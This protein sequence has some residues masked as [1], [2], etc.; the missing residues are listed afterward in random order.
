MGS[1]YDQALKDPQSTIPIR[2]CE[3]Q[4]I[5][6]ENNPKP[7][8]SELKNTKEM[9]LESLHITQHWVEGVVEMMDLVVVFNLGCRFQSHLSVSIVL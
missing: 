5:Q 7:C 4:K 1:S 6:D 8:I 2:R 3:L 9:S